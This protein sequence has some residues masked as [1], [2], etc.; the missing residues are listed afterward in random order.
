MSRC[1]TSGREEESRKPGATE[2]VIGRLRQALSGSQEAVV[3]ARA[4]R[5][6]HGRDESYHAD[7]DGLFPPDVVVFPKSNEEVSSVVRICADSRINIHA[8]GTLTS[9]EGHTAFL[10]GGVAV[11][12]THMNEV[13]DVNPEDMDCR[14]QAGVTRLQ[15]QQHLRDTG[16][17]FPV[18][19]G[20]DASIGG[21]ASC[22]A[23][24]TNAVRY[25][26]MK[27]VVKG[28]TAVLPNGE[29]IKTGGK[30]RKSSTGYDLTSLLVGSEGTLG[31][32]TEVQLKLS[33][34]PEAISSAVCNFQSMEGAVDSVVQIMQCGIPV[35]RVELLDEV[36]VSAV[37]SYSKMSIAE[38]PTLFF[39]FHGSDAG[40]REQ[41]EQCRSIVE[42]NGGGHF[43]WSASTEEREKL[44]RARHS[45]YYASLSMRVGCKCV[46]TDVCV[47]ISRLT[48]SILSTKALL[49]M[50]DILAPLVGHVGDGNFHVML[51]VDPED[52]EEVV[53]AK[54][55]S[56]EI[57]RAAISVGG[58]CSG[59]H[60]IGYGKLHLLEQ[61]HG[62]ESLGVMHAI[63]R[64]IDP[65]S[66]F[67][68]QKMGSK[69]W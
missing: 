52:E 22:R 14:V 12:M 64:A 60:G 54:K 21:M 32:I 49:A 33:G 9:L 41:T 3:T 58:T 11:D 62:I 17:F 37:N 68:P 1:L 15:L 67:N 25:G 29:V 44:W 59:E 5:E 7:A 47:P 42:D 34:Q 8:T 30:A 27:D 26:T 20:A 61:E 24:G 45:A 51:L 55:I 6:A 13:L 38:A 40:V 19:P 31:I 23:S 36:Q 69:F 28:L 66:L 53:L 2:D 50:H 56:E 46:I 35:A 18:D 10:R 63:K 48:E 39:E 16:L 65:H 57:A 4:V 43:Q